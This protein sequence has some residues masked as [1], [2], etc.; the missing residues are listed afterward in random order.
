MTVVQPISD[1]SVQLHELVAGHFTGPIRVLEPGGGKRTHVPLPAG[2]HVTVVDIDPEVLARNGR[3]VATT[4]LLGDIETMDYGEFDLVI[5]WDV[6]EHLENP[7]AAIDRMIAALAPGGLLIIKGPVL[8][9]LKGLITRFSPFW[10]HVLFYKVM[11]GSPK[12]GQPGYAPFRTVHGPG[13]DHRNILARLGG[14][15]ILRVWH[16]DPKASGLLAALYRILS[17]CGRKSDF[18]VVARSKAAPPQR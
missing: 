11:M 10:V 17:T 5:C 6:L 7:A 13:A 8:A 3:T 18:C 14:L 12:A 16:F 9:S 4:L 1:W 15:E 2:S